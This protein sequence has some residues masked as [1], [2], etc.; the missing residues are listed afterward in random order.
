[1]IY[2]E[3][4][5]VYL[6]FFSGLYGNTVGIFHLIDGNFAGADLGGALYDGFFEISANSD[7]LSGSVKITTKQ[8]A[9]LIT[10]ASSDLPISYVTTVTLKVPLENESH[11]EIVT[12]TGQVNVRFEK[13]RAI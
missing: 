6:G 8:G 5:G 1:M 13:L 3:I 4:N 9:S 2:R 10:G 11:H 7:E 12:S